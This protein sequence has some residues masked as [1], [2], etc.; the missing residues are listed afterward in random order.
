MEKDFDIIVKKYIKEGKEIDNIQEIFF[1]LLNKNDKKP[2]LKRTKKNRKRVCRPVLL[3]SDSS[4]DEFE[5][6]EN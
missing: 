5:K 6:R 3:I 2:N 4:C 1:K